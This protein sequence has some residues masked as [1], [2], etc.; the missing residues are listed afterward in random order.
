MQSL[1]VVF[2]STTLGLVV[3]LENLRVMMKYRVL[4]D[5]RLLLFNGE[6]DIKI[7]EVITLLQLT[8]STTPTGET[9]QTL[10]R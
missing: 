9:R 7:D 2:F 1:F 10:D 8:Q 4:Q 5:Y 3:K 6:G